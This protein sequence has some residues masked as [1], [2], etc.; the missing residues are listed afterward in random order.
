M[1]ATV[2]PVEMVADALKDCSRR[3]DLVLDPFCGSGTTIV[4]AEQTSRKARAIEIDPGFVDVAVRRWQSHA[5]KSA[6]L[7]GTQSS[8]EQ[9][10]DERLPG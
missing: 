3:G 5:G 8:F 9:I 6:L 7:A 2:K 10:E 1:H 4:A